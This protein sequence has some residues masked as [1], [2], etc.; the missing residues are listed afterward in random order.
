MVTREDALDL[1]SARFDDGTFLAALAR[2]VAVPTESQEPRG[3]PHLADYLSHEIRPTFETLGGQFHIYDNPVAGGPPIGVGML[4][5]DPSL[6][7][8]LVYGHGDTVRGQEGQWADGRDP[9]RLERAGDRIYGRGVAD[10]KGQHSVNLAALQTVREA[11]GRLGFNLRFLLEMA[12]E[13]GSTG[14]REFCVAQR[15][16]LSADLLIASDGPRLETHR[17][18]VFM[19]ARGAFNFDLSID[20]RAGGHHSGNWGGLLANPAI[21]LM[22]AIAS[23]VGP[24]GAIQVPELK[25]VAIPDAVRACLVG[26]S[27]DGGPDAPEIDPAWGEPGLTPAEKV[28]AWNTFEVLAMKAGNPDAPVNAIPPTARAHCQMRFTVDRDPETF[29]PAIQRHLAA[30]GFPEVVVTPAEKGYFNATRLDPEHPAAQWAVRSVARSAGRDPAVLPNLGGSLPNDLFAQLLGMPTIWVPHS[31]A[32]CSQHAPNEH[33][34]APVLR[35]GLRI[36]TGLFW[37]LGEAP[38]LLAR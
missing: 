23:L 29:L 18:T 20:L 19:G 15:D 10:N 12:E 9:W 17:P 24:T 26:L 34:L 8:V 37:D 7:T 25:P 5:E 33:G 38:P 36:M 4:D 14:L 30:S 28:F 6:P 31:Y 1:A 2:R 35:E 22:H 32:G 13:V 3:A 27:V 11:R 21:R 16:L